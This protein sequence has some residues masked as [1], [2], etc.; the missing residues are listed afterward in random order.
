MSLFKVTKLI[1]VLNYL[2]SILCLLVHHP[3]MIIMG[4]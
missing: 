3:D 4:C 2:G 1:S